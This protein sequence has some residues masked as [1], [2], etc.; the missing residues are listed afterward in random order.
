[1]MYTRPPP[2][3]PTGALFTTD[4]TLFFPTGLEEIRSPQNALT[5]KTLYTVPEMIRNTSV[6]ASC[7]KKICE[8]FEIADSFFTF[9]THPFAN[10]RTRRLT[11]LKTN[12]TDFLTSHAQRAVATFF[13]TKTL[14]VIL[15]RSARISPRQFLTHAHIRR[16]LS[17]VMCLNHMI[18]LSEIHTNYMYPGTLRFMSR[19]PNDLE[20]PNKTFAQEQP[21]F[22][23][24]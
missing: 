8:N 3:T 22:T 23:A 17:F 16:E 9:R 18:C 4:P 5:H 14:F 15:E 7:R 12:Q 24:V 2:Y 13:W 10:R 20:S 6:D 19:S 11:L 1:M 21:R